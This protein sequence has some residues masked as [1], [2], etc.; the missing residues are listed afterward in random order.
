[1]KLENIVRAA[2][3]VLVSGGCASERI[4]TPSQPAAQGLRVSET[5]RSAQPLFVIDGKIYTG[6]HPGTAVAPDQIDR[7]EVLKGERAVE[8]YGAAGANGVV[9][10]TTKAAAA[11]SGEQR[12]AAVPDGSVRIRGNAAVSPS[13][14]VLVDGREVPAASLRDIDA[15]DIRDIQ[16]LKGRA[17]V[18]QYGDRAADGVVVVRTKHAEDTL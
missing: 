15:D 7:I 2:A 12:T 11:A 18:E 1:M 8:T 17:A 14:L 5:G 13:L 6:E 3:I 10:I 16:V 9:V 4:A